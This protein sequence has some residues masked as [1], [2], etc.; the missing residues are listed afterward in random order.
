MPASR[1]IP[2]TSF[3]EARTRSVRATSDVTLSISDRLNSQ[4]PDHHHERTIADLEHG[5]GELGRRTMRGPDRLGRRGPGSGRSRAPVDDRQ[6]EI[7]F[8][9]ELDELTQPRSSFSVLF[10]LTM[11]PSIPALFAHSMCLLVSPAHWE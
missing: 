11:N 1:P 10:Q 6:L 9:R 4:V 3:S 8:A 5:S 2:S 7:R